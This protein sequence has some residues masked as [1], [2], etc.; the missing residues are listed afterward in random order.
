MARF[1][2]EGLTELTEDDIK[3]MTKTA[4]M[5][6]NAIRAKAGLDPI[7][8]LKATEM[9]PGVH[10][11]HAFD[12]NYFQPGTMVATYLVNDKG[13]PYRERL[14]LICGYENGLQIMKLN[15][16]WPSN[17]CRPYTISLDDYSSGRVLIKR[18]VKEE[19]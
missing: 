3:A 6:I 8:D 1:P 10:M 12:A 7:D 4:G 13:T 18:L 11:I 14:A 9:K 5:T 16:P 17:E 15:E 19:K 2:I